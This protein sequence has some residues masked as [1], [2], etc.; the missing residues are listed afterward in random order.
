[1]KINKMYF[2]I[3]ALI[4]AFGGCSKTSQCLK[5]DEYDSAVKKCPERSQSICVFRHPLKLFTKTK[6]YFGIPVIIVVKGGKQI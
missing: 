2:Q 1:M 3:I 5:W 6:I 4:L